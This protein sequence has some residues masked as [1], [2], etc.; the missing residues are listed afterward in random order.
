MTTT[1]PLWDHAAPYAA[2]DHEDEMPHLIPFIQPGSESAV[3]VC[4]G[5]AMDSW[6]IMKVLQ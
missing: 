2:Q 1:I 6:L 4:P 3:I 5:A